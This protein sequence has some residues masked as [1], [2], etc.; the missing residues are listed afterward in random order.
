MSVFFDWETRGK[1]IAGYN[2]EKFDTDFPS[3]P[4]DNFQE[5]FGYTSVAEWVIRRVFGLSVIGSTYR[6][7]SLPG[8]NIESRDAYQM[9]QLSLATEL[10]HSTN[11][12]PCLVECYATSDGEVEFYRVGST[13]LGSFKYLYKAAGAELQPKCD[14]VMVDGYDP[15]PKRYS[16]GREDLFT[17]GGKWPTYWLPGE[18]F[19]MCEEAFAKEGWI[20]Y[21]DPR[22]GNLAVMKE[23]GVFD[24]KK[25]ESIITYVYGIEVPFFDPAT[26][27]VSFSTQT[28]RYEE[29]NGFGDL[30]EFTWV[31]QKDTYVPARCLEVE[32]VGPFDGVS[33]PEADDDKFLG[34]QEVIIYGYAINDIAIDPQSKDPETG[35]YT[36]FLVNLDTM[37]PETFTLS[38][39]TDYIVVGDRI[40][41]A[42]NVYPSYITKY[43]GNIGEK[44]FVFRVHKRSI[45]DGKLKD[46][47]TEVFSDDVFSAA[48][49][50]LGQGQRAYGVEKVVIR[51][52]WDNH[53]MYFKSIDNI[54]DRAALEGVAAEFY[55]IIMR[56]LPPP[57]A[58][59]GELLDPS[60]IITDLYPETVE[61]ISGKDYIR[62]MAS[63]EAGDIRVTMPFAN[64]AECKTI[65][66]AI[67][68]IQNDVVPDIVYTC[69]PDSE[70]ELGR[71][72]PDGNYVN[73]IDYSY[74]D[75]S[76]YLI[77]VHAGPLWYGIGSWDQAIYKMRTD[78]VSLEGVII[79]IGVNNTE[80]TVQIDSIGAMTC[81]N[82][83]QGVLSVGDRVQVAVYNNPVSY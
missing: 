75:G 6:G 4:R 82:G 1:D 54:I 37:I 79:G 56:N 11:N 76:Q 57:R 3:T 30:H 60:E 62:S 9:V 2:E 83:C 5:K 38:R 13:G 74:Q 19:P 63:L 52:S 43:G 51:Y 39:G 17:F 10:V 45:F 24:P 34:V 81:V 65:S 42:C 44:R 69:S 66:N 67:K 32:D 15:P 49:F 35:D 21:A 80:A 23:K 70:V 53:Q 77:S 12:V 61:N 50:P 31:D 48:V 28:S 59:N 58:V 36:R 33:I 72:L 25:Y 68:S 73:S 22:I 27:S 29:L 71:R 47:V 8:Y 40:V 55:P 16:A 46:G 78:R 14:N 41:F 7:G 64:G 26:V 18:I 20:E